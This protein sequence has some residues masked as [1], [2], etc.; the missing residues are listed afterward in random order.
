MDNQ[1]YPVYD[2]QK[3]LHDAV[4][5]LGPFVK[6]NM[7]SIVP[8]KFRTDETDE[9]AEFEIDHAL[10]PLHVAYDNFLAACLY[11]EKIRFTKDGHVWQGPNVTGMFTH[12]VRR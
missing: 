1:D 7:L 10:P 8:G 9:G 12:V 2:I 5:K 6:G 3:Q 4:D 11:G